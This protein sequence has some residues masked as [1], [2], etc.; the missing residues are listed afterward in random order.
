[1]GEI[2]ATLLDLDRQRR[3]LA[4]IDK[5]TDLILKRETDLREVDIDLLNTELRRV[6]ASGAKS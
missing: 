6:L 5:V 3:E 1:M 2:R 4:D